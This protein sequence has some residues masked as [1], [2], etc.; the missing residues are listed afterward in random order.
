MFSFQKIL[1]L[2]FFFQFRTDGRR[3]SKNVRRRKKSIS[4][5]DLQ[6][7]F[8]KGCIEAWKTREPFTGPSFP[9]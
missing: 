5:S 6:S 9:D 3:M 8:R 4:D 7:T 2:K 1:I